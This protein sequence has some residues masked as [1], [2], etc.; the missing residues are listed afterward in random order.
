MRKPELVKGESGDGG[1]WERTGGV[2]G[3]WWHT[4]GVCPGRERDRGG[5]PPRKPS[6]T[7]TL[8]AAELSDREKSGRRV[9]ELQ[10]DQEG[11]SMPLSATSPQ[12]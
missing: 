7:A 6:I 4:D 5:R 8:R 11:P 2:A 3:L 12:A 9:T 10:W 1:L